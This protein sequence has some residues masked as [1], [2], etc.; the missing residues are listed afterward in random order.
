VCW[1]RRRFGLKVWRPKPKDDDGKDEKTQADIN[2]AVLLAKE[3]M[4]PV[5]SDMSELYL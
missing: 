5:D 2:M 4:A 3:F 1:I